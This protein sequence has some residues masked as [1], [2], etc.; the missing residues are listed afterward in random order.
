M[1]YEYL[2]HQQTE[3]LE[4]EVRHVDRIRIKSVC[5]LSRVAFCRAGQQ[6]VFTFDYRFSSSEWLSGTG[7]P[8]AT[9]FP[10]CIMERLDQGLLHPPLEHRKTNMSCLGIKPG[11]PV[12]QVCT[13]TKSYS[14]R[15]CCCYS[16]L[17]HGCPSACGCYM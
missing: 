6:L 8:L 1:R 17:L 11:S 5:M 12:S 2:E 14:N 13:L 4:T 3:K 7:C 9:G 16:E 15:L 10:L